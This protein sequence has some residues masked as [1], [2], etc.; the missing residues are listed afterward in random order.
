MWVGLVST[1]VRGW[2]VMGIFIFILYVNKFIK[3]MTI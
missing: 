3:K 1:H 2:D